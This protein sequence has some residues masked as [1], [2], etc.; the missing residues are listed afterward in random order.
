MQM[1]YLIINFYSPL[2]LGD[3]TIL[4]QTLWLVEQADPQAAF[5]VCVSDGAWLPDL[6]RVRWV[7]NW[8][9][10]VRGPD[11]ARA[12]A[13][14]RQAHARADLIL[15]LGGGYFFV[16]DHRPVSTWATL[17]LAYALRWGKPVICLPQSFGPF[18]HAYQARLAAWL[19]SRCARVMLRDPESL[20][21]YARH[22][23]PTHRA[24]YAPDVA[25]TL[26]LRWPSQP[27]ARPLPPAIGATVVDW[28]PVD[29]QLCSAQAG[30]ERAMA[31]LLAYAVVALGA[32][33]RLFVQCQSQRRRFESDLAASQR[34]RAQVRQQLPLDL[35][36]RIRIVD[37]LRWPT[38]AAAAYG[39][40]S[41][42]IATRLHSAIIAATQGTPVLAFGYQPKT[43]AAMRLLGQAEHSF[44]LRA[45]PAAGA[46][47]ARLDALWAARAHVG[48]QIA[49]TAQ[50]LGQ[51][52]ADALRGALA[53]Y[54][55]R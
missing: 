8:N 54:L 12:M 11:R 49:R 47:R 17:A 20:A 16:H 6:P 23:P 39:Q 52:S 55:S 5:D 40:M 31:D 21:L 4:E 37:D 15:S 28:S 44:D 43:L 18:R 14:L 46:L 13:A 19:M 48:E 53:A 24:Q 27:D 32:E 41:A 25:F 51:A 7:R 10:A 9:F 35:A 50:Q 42:F 2:N 36:E 38:E 22:A 3:L 1:H 30:Y 34:V 33:V 29:P 45:L 26:A